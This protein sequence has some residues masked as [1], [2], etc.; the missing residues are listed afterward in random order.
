MTT[1]VEYKG[2]TIATVDNNTKTLLTAGKYC[3]GDIK[4]TDV[5]GPAEDTLLKALRNQVT[6]VSDDE[7]TSI[8]SYGLAYMTAL[9]SSY[10]SERRV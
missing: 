2:N 3:E 8:R 6:S 7:L 9:T 4:L 5:S 1:T 10:H